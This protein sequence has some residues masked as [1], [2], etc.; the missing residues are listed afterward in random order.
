MGGPGGRA[1]DGA[2]VSDE[3]RDPEVEALLRNL[4]GEIE[5]EIPFPRPVG[6]VLNILRRAIQ[7]GIELGERRRRLD[8]VDALKGNEAGEDWDHLLD[9]VEQLL[10]SEAGDVADAV[11]EE[12][13]AC[14]RAVA[15]M[16]LGR[17]GLI[18]RNDAVDAIRARRKP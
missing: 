7:A 13:E 15:D 11:R 5:A 16:L 6:E 4:Q 8:L 17:C 2:A 14:E 9:R 18:S 12:N 3:S 10:D 1:G